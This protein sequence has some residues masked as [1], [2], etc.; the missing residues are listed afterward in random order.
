MATQALLKSLCYDPR[1]Q[2]TVQQTKAGLPYYD[3]NPYDFEQWHFVVM[4]KY[5]AYASKKDVEVQTQDRIELSVK[6]IEGL[7]ND[8]LKCA[9]DL[10]RDVVVAPDGVLRIAEAIEASWAGKLEIA[11]KE[12][13]REGGK[14]DGVLARVPGESMASYVSR[15]RRLY[16]SLTTHDKTFSIP[17]HL[18][19][20]SPTAVGSSRRH[21]D[22]RIVFNLCVHQCHEHVGHMLMKSQKMFV[23]RMS[24][25]LMTTK[26]TCRTMQRT[27]ANHAVRMES[28]VTWWIA[29]NKT[30]CSWQLTALSAMRTCAST[31]CMWKKSCTASDPNKS[32]K[33]RDVESLSSMRREIRHAGLVDGRATGLVIKFAQILLEIDQ[34]LEARRGHGTPIGAETC[35][36][37]QKAHEGQ[38]SAERCR[39]THILPDESAIQSRSS[40]CASHE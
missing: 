35:R 2:D 8:A 17:E 18:T 25:M 34:H 40:N 30:L 11:T 39:E 24:T 38:R 22:P 14:K 6:V 36:R 23:G 33:S 37:R 5:D 31:V 7:K 10:G 27:G 16:R 4:G 26:M 19:H 28:S 13:Y 12:L 1:G 29:W 32:W 21:I 20:R 9:M 15:R 3:G